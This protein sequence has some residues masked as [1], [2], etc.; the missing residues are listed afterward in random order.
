LP[1]TFSTFTRGKCSWSAPETCVS[2]KGVELFPLY[3][4]NIV[5]EQQIWIEGMLG[6][7]QKGE[8]NTP[9]R[10][11]LHQLPTPCCSCR[12]LLVI[13]FKETMHMDGPWISTSLTIFLLTM[14]VLL[15]FFILQQG[16]IRWLVKRDIRL[17]LKVEIIK[18]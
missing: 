18:Y 13:L 11:K 9:P 5:L 12:L 16:L 17:S 15:F 2:N 7:L 8:K 3:F 6:K 1:K 4:L 14:S 10:P